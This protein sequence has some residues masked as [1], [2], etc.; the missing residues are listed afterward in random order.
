MHCL[1]DRREIEEGFKKLRPALELR[2]TQ[3]VE[4]HKAERSSL[5]Q[6]QQQRETKEAAAR[7]ARLPEKGFGK[8]WS[9]ITGKYSTL[10]AQNEHDS[11]QALRR[12]QA[13]RDKTIAKQLEERQRLQAAIRKTREERI[14]ELSALRQEIANY[15]LMQ[16][17]KSASITPDRAAIQTSRARITQT[18]SR[19]TYGRERSRTR[20]RGPDFER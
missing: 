7:A 2:R 3:M 8:L 19:D 1:G 13:E 18:S 5:A 20:D 17:G 15:L 9:R 11:W 10:K 16:Q 4:R 12:D 6:Y 14:Q